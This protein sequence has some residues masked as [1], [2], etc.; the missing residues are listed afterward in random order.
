MKEELPHEGGHDTGSYASASP[1]TDG[2]HVFAF[3]G[4]SGLFCLDLD[5]NVFWEADLGDM[6]TKHGHGEGAS[7]VLFGETLVVNWD[8]EGDSFIVALDKRTGEERWR[9]GRDEVTSWATPIVVESGSRAQVVV[10][11]TE[12][13]RGYD[14]ATGK[15]LWS[16]GGLS[17]NVVASP[18]FEDG[19]LYAASSYE[20]QAMIAVRI[21]GAEGDV[22]LTD[23]VLWYRR[24]NT[25]YVPSPLLVGDSLYILH[26]YQGVLAHIDKH[27]GKEVHRSRRL[28]GIDHVYASPVA[29]AGRV[30]ITDLDGTT[31]VLAHGDDPQV[32]AVNQLDDSFSA[33]AVPVDGE[34]FLRGDRFLYC[35]SEP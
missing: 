34:L 11:G 20:K 8:H 1:V 14:L 18:V 24:K 9:A 29:A 10:S 17:H 35:I 2:E 23:R 28:Q 5:G 13:I 30:Y 31:I 19:V 32:L 21:D 33:S 27:T 3:F 15:V 26:H 22:S 7:P 16:C 12:R 25:P 4:S 6:Q